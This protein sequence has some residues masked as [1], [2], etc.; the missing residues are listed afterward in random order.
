MTYDI[1]RWLADIGLPQ[2]AEVFQIHDID[3]ALLARAALRLR[4]NAACAE[5][6]A[7]LDAAQSLIARTDARTDARTL[8]PALLEWRAELAAL[9][10]DAALRA[11]PPLV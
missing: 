3:L 7:A 10:G 2:Y 6:H 11:G 4:G 5:A 1:A 8:A 9:C